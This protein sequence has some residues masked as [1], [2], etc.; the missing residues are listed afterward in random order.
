MVLD[1][2][3]AYLEAHGVGVLGTTLFKGGIPV[4]APEVVMQDTLVALVETPGLPPV[5]TLDFARY[6]QPVVQVIA[7]GAP[8]QYAA[9]RLQA[10]AAFDALDGL[11]NVTLGTGVYLWVIALQ[12]PWWLRTDD[13]ARPHIVFQVRAARAL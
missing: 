5:H 4:D 1:D 2:L 12:S 8:Y 7:R 10:Q 13:F 6:E 9:C 11:A 3:G